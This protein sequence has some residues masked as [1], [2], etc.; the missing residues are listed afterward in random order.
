MYS[1]TL[2]LF[3]ILILL[4]QRKEPVPFETYRR[5]KLLFQSDRSRNGKCSKKVKFDVVVDGTN[6]EMNGQTLIHLIHFFL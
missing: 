5:G 6:R 4:I 1:L 2:F 3:P